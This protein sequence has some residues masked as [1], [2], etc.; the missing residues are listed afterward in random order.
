MKQKLIAKI[1]VIKN[2]S[3][4]DDDIYRDILVKVTGKTSCKDMNMKELKTVIE[5]FNNTWYIQ[6]I[7]KYNTFE[8]KS[9]FTFVETN[10]SKMRKIF[11]L[12][13][14]LG[15]QEKLRDSS[16]F[17][18]NKFLEKRFNTSYDRLNTNTCN[19]STKDKVIEA[20]KR[21]NTRRTQ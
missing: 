19:N 9:K 20:L 5:E 8:S 17:G 15:Q 10:C 4:L 2:K 3:G 14:E 1:H 21:W 6:Q 12:W 18:L 11:K 13:S 7:P 16:N